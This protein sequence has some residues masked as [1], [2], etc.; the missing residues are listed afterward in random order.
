M[1]NEEAQE[2]TD[3]ALTQVDERLG[4]L[5]TWSE[6]RRAEQARCDTRHALSA[7]WGSETVR[8][9]RLVANNFDEPQRVPPLEAL[10]DHLDAH[11]RIARWDAQVAR[12]RA[13]GELARAEAIPNV[14]ARAGGLHANET[15]EVAMEVETT[16]PLPL[17][18]RR[19][20]DRIAARLEVRRAEQQR[21]AARL[22]LQQQLR[23]VYTDLKLSVDELRAL[24]ENVL[25]MA[26]EAL[27]A[28]GQGEVS[29]ESLRGAQQTL[30][31]VRRRRLD[32]L[33]AYHRALIEV[34]QLVTRSLAGIQISV[35]E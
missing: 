23:S 10:M 3:A 29:P 17:F 9:D 22:Q 14:E 2:S 35:D 20:G 16:L 34:E 11:P 15:E 24:D 27:K 5:T 21:H 25:P 12:H 6:Q 18:N 30:L 26:R 4:R 13:A 7:M 31:D 33:G 28:A 8:F 19:Q 32:A 1:D